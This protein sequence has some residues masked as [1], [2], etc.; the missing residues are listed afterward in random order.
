MAYT[1]LETNDMDMH[2]LIHKMSKR[3]GWY[4][5]KIHD[6]YTTKDA[7]HLKGLCTNWLYENFQID[8]KIKRLE[9]LNQEEIDRGLGLIGIRFDFSNGEG[10][11]GESVAFFDGKEIKGISL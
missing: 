1:S 5:P 3:A 6:K 9:I 4:V 11:E 7:D 10:F 8:G 2:V